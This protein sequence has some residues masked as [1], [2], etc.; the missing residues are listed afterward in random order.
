MSDEQDKTG[1]GPD[2]RWAGEALDRAFRAAFVR[3]DRRIGL[4]VSLPPASLDAFAIGNPLERI[5]RE[6]N[7]SS[8]GSGASRKRPSRDRAGPRW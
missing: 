5:A 1:Q 6:L 7:P 3:L 8:A 4:L 2:P